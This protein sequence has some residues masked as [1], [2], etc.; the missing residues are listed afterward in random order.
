MKPATL[1]LILS[2]HLVDYFFLDKKRA[3]SGA[4]RSVEQGPIRVYLSEMDNECICTQR[5]I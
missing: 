1:P 3:F 5:N 4:G 2:Q